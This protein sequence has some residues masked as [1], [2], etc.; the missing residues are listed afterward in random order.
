MGARL[1]KQDRK[2]A[3]H[4]LVTSIR[5]SDDLRVLEVRPVV[6][7][8]RDLPFYSRGRLSWG[9]FGQAL[10]ARLGESRD[11]GALVLG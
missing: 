1:T 10:A 4:E 6:K 11:C 7:A 9:P 5:T 8:R 2:A 3:A